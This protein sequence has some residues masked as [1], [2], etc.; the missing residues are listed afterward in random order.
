MTPDEIHQLSYEQFNKLVNT[1]LYQNQGII[2][3]F[4]LISHEIVDE[5]VIANYLIV[6]GFH[7]AT[8]KTYRKV[9]SCVFIFSTLTETW[10]TFPA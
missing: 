2:P 5:T 6:N 8:L 4:L 3:Y 1:I 10:K 9:S 7:D